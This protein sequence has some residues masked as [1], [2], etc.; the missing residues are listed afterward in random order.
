MSMLSE[1]A[2]KQLEIKVKPLANQIK[3]VLISDLRNDPSNARNHSKNL[4][5]I[6]ASLE[7]FGQ[8]K[9]IIAMTDGTVICGNG[10]FAAAASLG[11]ERLNVVYT[12]LKGNEAIAYALADNRTSEL[13]EWDDE[14]LV[15]QLSY[16]Q[17]EDEELAAAAGFSESE[18]AALVA[19]MVEVQEDEVPSVQAV[20]IT[21]PNDLWVLGGHRLLCGDSTKAEDVNRLM[22]GLQA[23]LML[24]DPPYNVDYTGKTKDAL[25]VDNDN[26]ED[27]D[28]RKFLVKAFSAG[29]NVMKAGAAFY[30]F[31]ADS[32][33]Y[34]F[35]GAVKDCQ[36][37]VRQCLIWMKNSMVMGRQDYHWQHEPCLYG[38]KEGAAH[39][40]YAD[41]KQTTIMQFDRPKQNQEHP[42][43]KPV[44]L[45]AYL[46][47]NNSAPKDL[48][49]DPF[50]GSGTTLIAAEQLMRRCYG[51][52][53][54]PAY[55]DVVV[56]RWETKTG[57]K[58]KLSAE[59]RRGKKGL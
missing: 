12:N 39:N 15:K 55:C 16:L 45:V 53:I 34:N 58:A 38:W 47:E 43:M 35:R 2:K 8:Q 32:E 3:S 18:I 23:D 11:W 22:D 54:S 36:Q 14:A 19:S 30:I 24:T 50:L 10:V 5:V 57:M 40:W 20:T 33:G 25:K 46:L 49:Y 1:M 52:E 21:K 7:K 4:D 42:T 6:Q 48:V 37:V 9:P 56:K 51:M 17:S 13:A 28:F 41:R 59:V 27:V 31:H 26:M 44:A 29:F